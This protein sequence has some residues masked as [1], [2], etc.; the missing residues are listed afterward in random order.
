MYCHPVQQ[1]PSSNNNNNTS[2]A[3]A[4]NPHHH[5]HNKVMQYRRVPCKARG[6]KSVHVARTAWIDIPDGALHGTVLLCSNAEC[7]GS[8]RRFR[9]CN[10][11]DMP[12][13][14]RN[15]TKRHSHG[16]QKSGPYPVYNRAAIPTSPIAA[17][18]PPTTTTSNHDNNNGHSSSSSTTSTKRRKV[19]KESKDMGSIASQAI[20]LES[21]GA[22]KNI[23]R[24]D[25]DSI[26]SAGLDNMVGASI[27]GAT[28]NGNKNAGE[29][30][31]LT[32]EEVQWI[33]MFRCRPGADYPE[34]MQI[35]SQSMVRLAKESTQQQQPPADNNNNN[36]ESL[37]L[38]DVGDDYDV[39]SDNECFEGEEDISML[40]ATF[41]DE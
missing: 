24:S 14:A 1:E 10:E 35:W 25:A 33:E 32:K 37:M 13:A 12:V 9:F 2:T 11:C 27:V 6:V 30:M 39:A 17:A 18:V 8:G 19:S 22:N 40:M 20:E 34:Q 5:H 26:S 21:F 16:V 29:Q 36:N 4:A 7:S 41:F 15:F 3:A 31:L 23:V 28:I 38:Q